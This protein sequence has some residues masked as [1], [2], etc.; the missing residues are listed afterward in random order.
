MN[1]DTDTDVHWRHNGSKIVFDIIKS[2][3]SLETQDPQYKNR[4][5]TFAL[6]YLRGNFSIKLN[7][8]QHTDA[9]KFSCFITPSNE[10][11]TVEL[12]VNGV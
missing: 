3:D 7:N 2:K 5:E 1:S 9:G 8:L 6:E 10:Q 4:T 11:Q 12:Q